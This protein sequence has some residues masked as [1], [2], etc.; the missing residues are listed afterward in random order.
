MPLIVCGALGLLGPPP[1]PPPTPPPPPCSPPPPPHAPGIVHITHDAVLGDI[2]DDALC[3]AYR[4]D[5]L[6]RGY[7]RGEHD[8]DIRHCDWGRLYAHFQCCGKHEGRRWGCQPPPVPGQ[9]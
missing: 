5:D 2:S 4:Y 9:Q 8:H 1:A 3:Y 7:C 6:L